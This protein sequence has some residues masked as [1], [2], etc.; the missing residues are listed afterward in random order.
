[1]FERKPNSKSTKEDK[2]RH[3]VNKYLNREYL[4]PEPDGHGVI[5]GT[6]AQD[7]PYM[8][9]LLSHGML[10][11]QGDAG[12]TALARAVE[13]DLPV[14]AEFLLQN[15][16]DVD[17]TTDVARNTPLH[18]AT[19]LSHVDCVKILL[20]HSADHMLK[21]DETQVPLD[22]AI[23]NNDDA[24][25][26]LI[27]GTSSDLSTL[28]WERPPNHGKTKRVAFS[29]GRGGKLAT[30]SSHAIVAPVD[31]WQLQEIEV[32]SELPKDYSYKGGGGGGDNGYTAGAAESIYEP[33]YMN[34]RTCKK[35][36]WCS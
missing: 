4:D 14:A 2:Q 16:V 18:I 26:S 25:C 9:R 32:Q 34:M 3:I 20:R 8:L 1:M 10:A 19:R 23:A 17:A 12:V 31:E 33:V 36:A 35:N 13:L 15:G 7:L 30:T 6:M 5:A 11:Q 21:N 22:Y 27:N 24:C 28:V 29:G